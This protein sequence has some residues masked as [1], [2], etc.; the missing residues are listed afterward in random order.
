MSSA[1]SL[2]PT[3]TETSAA[4]PRRR[5]LFGLAAVG[6]GLAGAG[7]AWCQGQSGGTQSSAAE[8]AF[9]GLEFETPQGG[10]LKM[11]ALKGSPLLVNFWATWCPP[12][13]EEL[14]MLD[15]FYRDNAARQV[16]VIGLAVDKTQA[17]RNFLQKTPI[18]FPM[19]ITGSAGLELCQGLG[20][21]GGALPFSLAMGAD[22]LVKH[23]KMGKI[24]AQ[25]LKDWLA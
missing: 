7:L 22:G 9:W 21:T 8:Q 5:L 23:R 16:Q 2:P 11:S 13:I 25:E 4:A 1:N 10:L 15:Q 14:P 12:C 18:S 24:T 20:N 17:V 6:A 3:G 19:G